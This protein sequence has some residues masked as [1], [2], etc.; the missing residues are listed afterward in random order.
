LLFRRLVSH[1]ASGLV[2][3]FDRAMMPRKMRG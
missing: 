1:L 2:A 3:S